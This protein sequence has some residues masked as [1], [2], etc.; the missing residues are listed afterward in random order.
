MENAQLISLS[1]QMGLQRQMDVV[2]NNLANIN[3]TGFKSEDVLFE[4]YMMPKVITFC[5]ELPKTSTGKTP[6]G[7]K[8]VVQR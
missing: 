8:K 3:T 1:R 4:D 5:A 2:A 7:K 6:T